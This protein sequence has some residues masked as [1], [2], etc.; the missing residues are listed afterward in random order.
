MSRETFW[1]VVTGV[2][3]R[4]SDNRILLLKRSR[5]VRTYPQKWHYVSGSVESSDDGSLVKRLAQEILEETGLAHSTYSIASSWARP[6]L[7]D[8]PGKRGIMV[9]AVLV[10]LTNPQA[11]VTLNVENEEYCWV[12]PT[13]LEAYAEEAVPKFFETYLRAVV[14]AKPYDSAFVKRLELDRSHGA[15]ELAKW[16]GS[17]II[18]WAQSSMAE[19]TLLLREELLELSYTLATTRADMTPIAAAVMTILENAQVNVLEADIPLAT[20]VKQAAENVDSASKSTMQKLVEQGCEVLKQAV[21]FDAKNPSMRRIRVITVSHSSTVRQVLLTF[22]LGNPE[23]QVEVIIPESR[24]LNEGVTLGKQ[25][26]QVNT[27]TPVLITDAQIA[28]FMR[29]A[30]LALVGADSIDAEGSVKNK[31]GTY[32]L[33]LAAKEWDI[34]MYCISDLSKIGRVVDCVARSSGDVGLEEFGS[35]EQSSEEVWQEPNTNST[36]REFAKRAQIRNVYFEPTPAK[37]FRGVICERGVL[38]LQDAQ[39]I[40]KQFDIRF[41]LLLLS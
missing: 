10:R 35:E 3:K 18:T 29:K 12:D 39:G 5:K 23:V 4:T 21:S 22:A 20:R 34:P 15:A 25:L 37:Y 17:A 24:P 40:A 33:A 16:A 31:V 26:L 6:L 7:I 28:V 11:K 32:L 8:R 1:H 27:I 9:H 2:V 19:K 41:K 38:S 36:D 14:G 13:K 30:N